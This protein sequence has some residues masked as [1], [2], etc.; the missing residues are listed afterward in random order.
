MQEISLLYRKLMRAGSVVS[1]CL[2]I[3]GLALEAL[4]TQNALHSWSWRSGFLYLMLGLIIMLLTPVA[5]L[6][7]VIIYNIKLKQYPMVFLAVILLA[8]LAGGTWLIH[9][10]N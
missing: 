1:L 5:G 3:A 9:P 2:L 10:G 7:T 6:I 8:L 4:G